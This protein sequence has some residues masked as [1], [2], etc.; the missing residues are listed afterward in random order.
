MT[1]NDL[2]SWMLD[3]FDVVQGPKTAYYHQM[4]DGKE[5]K[6]RYKVVR[7][8][9]RDAKTRTEAWD[10]LAREMQSILR[11]EGGSVPGEHRF[12][13]LGKFNGFAVP[14]LAVRAALEFKLQEY[15]EFDKT[16]SVTTSAQMAGKIIP[17]GWQYDIETDCHYPVLRKGH[18]EICY[19]RYCIEH[20]TVE[21]P[22]HEGMPTLFIGNGSHP[23]QPVI[24]GSDPYPAIYAHSNGLTDPGHCHGVLTAGTQKKNS[25]SLQAMLNGIRNSKADL[26]N[27]LGQQVTAHVKINDEAHQ[28]TCT[29]LET[30]NVSQWPYGPP[31]YKDARAAVVAMMQEGVICSHHSLKQRLALVDSAKHSAKPLSAKHRGMT[32]AKYAALVAMQDAPKKEPSHY[33][34]VQ[35]IKAASVKPESDSYAAPKGIIG[36]Q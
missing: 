11:D 2:E 19:F 9:Y 1:P 10:V 16:Q 22:S 33:E 25:P 12:P 23:K 36:W 6:H 15:T 14:K 35:A 29:L 8:G 20:A 3:N 4:V 21:Y 18:D 5:V 34:Q 26:S 27:L 31:S 24:Y 30:L 28:I 7:L 17:P 32:E 13:I